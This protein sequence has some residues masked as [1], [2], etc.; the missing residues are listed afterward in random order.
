MIIAALAWWLCP[1]VAALPFHW[2]G[3]TLDIHPLIRF[4]RFT[5]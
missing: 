5:L 2:I 3:V 1:I 4:P